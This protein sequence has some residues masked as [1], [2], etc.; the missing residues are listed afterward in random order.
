MNHCIH[1]LPLNFPNYIENSKASGKIS[2]AE[3]DLEL[4]GS[5]T[6]VTIGCMLANFAAHSWRSGCEAHG[7]F[8]IT[9]YK[10]RNIILQQFYTNILWS[11]TR[12]TILGRSQQNSPTNQTR[13]APLV[14]M[15]PSTPPHHSCSHFAFKPQG[16][17]YL[18]KIILMPLT[19]T[20]C[21]R[22]L[23]FD[24]TIPPPSRAKT[25]NEDASIISITLVG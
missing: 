2:R 3:V 19:I 5:S 8:S 16:L 20:H 1:R 11:F 15:H 17:R 13:G 18:S 22:D 21:R 23:H 9:L 12:S 10:Y 4:R 24:A 7:S 6:M 25:S 14:Y